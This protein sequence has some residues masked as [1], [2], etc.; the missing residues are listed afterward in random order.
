[1]FGVPSE[2]FIPIEIF[3][4]PINFINSSCDIGGKSVIGSLMVAHVA[5]FSSACGSDDEEKP[6]S[7]SG[8]VSSCYVECGDGTISCV[9]LPGIT[10]ASCR[11]SA[12]ENC[13]AAPTNV[14]FLGDGWLGVANLG[15][16]HLAAL[17]VQ[18]PGAPLRYPDLPV[19]GERP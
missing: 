6:G 4:R 9:S 13:G 12:E 14:A 3:V 10:E 5:L 8:D 2:T 1:M 15:R 17:P 19:P 11:S 18:A 16:W 7:Q